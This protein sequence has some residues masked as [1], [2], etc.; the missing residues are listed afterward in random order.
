[1]KE[2]LITENI[3]LIYHVLKQMNLYDEVNREKYFDIGMIALVKAANHF[4]PDKGYL[5]TTLAGKVIRTEIL[6]QIRYE[7]LGKRRQEQYNLSLDLVIDNNDGDETTLMDAIPSDYNLE[8]HVI[9]REQIM[10]LREA[11]KTELTDKER[12][13]LMLYLD[14]KTQCEIAEEF[15]VVQACIS[16][17][18]KRIIE[19]LKR[20][21]DE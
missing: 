4:D 11:I 9:R 14:G 2:S 5:F 10:L 15:G 1:M 17:Y 12:R 3:N 7:N 16:R 19:K 6:T 8:E 13:I 18:I 21:V 20:K